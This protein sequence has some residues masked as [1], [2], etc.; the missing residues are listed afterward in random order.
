MNAFSSLRWPSLSGDNWW[1]GHA[2]AFLKYVNLPS[3]AL[4]HGRVCQE[5]CEAAYF[6]VV[7]HHL[8]SVVI[9]VRGTETPEDLITDGL[10]R[11]CLLSRDDLDGLI[12][13]SHI[14]P[15]VKRRVESSFP[16]YGHSGIVEAA[17]DLYIQIEGDLADNGNQY[18]FLLHY[19]S[20]KLSWKQI[21]LHIHGSFVLCY[22]S[23]TLQFCRSTHV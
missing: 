1:R 19:L 5:K 9:S 13:S 6:V 17:R 3:E 14:Q 2:A 18:F 23:M 20:T 16:H 4:R 15:D 12:N 10:G 7:L 21:I 11:E 8:R 22:I